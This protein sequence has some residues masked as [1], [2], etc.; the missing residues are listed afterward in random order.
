ME[1]MGVFEWSDELLVGNKNLDDQ[2]K[3]FFALANS[4]NV[5]NAS[6]D[7]VA[8]SLITLIEFAEE[9]LTFEERELARVGYRDALFHKEI[10][11]QFRKQLAILVQ[12]AMQGQNEKGVMIE[13]KSFVTCWLYQHIRLVDS[14]YKPYMS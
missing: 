7:S 5:V 14:L 2:H 4:I 6:P 3:Q 10:H 12:K 1:M 11:D 8:S 13:I 9:H